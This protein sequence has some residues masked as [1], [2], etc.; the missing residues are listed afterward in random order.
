MKDIDIT[1]LLCCTV[2]IGLPWCSAVKNLPAMW[3][4]WVR[5]L[6]QEDPP[7]EGMATQYSCLGESHGQGRKKSDTIEM[8]EHTL[9]MPSRNQHSIVVHYTSIK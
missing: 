6:G 5:A 1:E 4:S 2:E 3:E 7:E 8:T 9:L